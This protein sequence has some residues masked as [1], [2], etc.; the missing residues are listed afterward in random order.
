MTT[1]ALDLAYTNGAR[2]WMRVGAVK[3]EA[4]HRTQDDSVGK[5]FEN[6]SKKP[7][8]FISLVGSGLLGYWKTLC[9]GRGER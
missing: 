1:S 8:S 3:E 9:D 4:P 5:G 6:N 7:D 2:Q